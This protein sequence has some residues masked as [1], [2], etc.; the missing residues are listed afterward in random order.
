[1]N[2]QSPPLLSWKS[3]FLAL[4]TLCATIGCS[5][6]Q[7]GASVQPGPTGG[8]TPSQDQENDPI[9]VSQDDD[10]SRLP[11]QGNGTEPTSDG[12]T[13]ETPQAEAPD[14][15]LV[16]NPGTPDTS[17]DDTTP[18]T[19]PTNP[20][21]PA[22]DPSI[23]DRTLYGYTVSG[24]KNH[25]TLS[26][27]PV[28]CAAMST[29][30]K[31]RQQ[32]FGR[33]CDALSLVRTNCPCDLVLCSQAIPEIT[34]INP[35][36]HEIEF[37]GI[38]QTGARTSCLL[39]GPIPQCAQ[40]SEA[41][42]AD[43][44]AYRTTCLAA[45]FEVRECACDWPLCSQ[46]PGTPT[47]FDPSLNQRRFKGYDPQGEVQ[48]CLSEGLEGMCV[49]LPQQELDALTAYAATCTAFGYE[50]RTGICHCTLCSLPIPQLTSLDPTTDQ[51]DFRGYDRTGKIQSCTSGGP[52]VM[53][54][55]VAPEVITAEKAYAAQ[56]QA[57]GYEVRP[58]QCDTILCSR[59]L[60]L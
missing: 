15:P 39:G 8:D 47:T 10:T 32:T 52:Q 34:T 4:I 55:E 35:Q 18:G 42:V 57:A 29:A 2:F 41:Q 28:S 44:Q 50:V 27:L 21:V 5:D 53:C 56:C 11:S 14:N 20:A 16:E 1:M 9:L 24:V 45:G 60:P 26:E 7:E 46:N 30:E 54:V 31:E 43:N 25:C 36:V 37:W 13:P 17:E 22:F 19:A 12:T 38:D 3:L 51:V 48:S 58:C 49:L 6:L 40:L 33:Q 59:P 23:D